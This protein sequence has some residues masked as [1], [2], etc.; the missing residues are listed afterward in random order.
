MTAWSM[1]RLRIVTTPAYM[2]DAR[3]S[4]VEAGISRWIEKVL[5]MA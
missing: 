2:Y 5:E 1:R 4:E 3:I